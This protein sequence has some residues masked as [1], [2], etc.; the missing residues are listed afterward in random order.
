MNIFALLAPGH[1]P[2]GKALSLG[3]ELLPET[4]CFKSKD[5]CQRLNGAFFDLEFS[6]RTL[7]SGQGA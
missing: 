5:T 6:P 1:M 3:P 4:S 7:V 2:A